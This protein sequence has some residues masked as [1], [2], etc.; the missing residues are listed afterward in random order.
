MLSVASAA[1]RRDP[2]GPGDEP[3]DL[4]K[5][6]LYVSNFNG[7]YGDEWLRK[8]KKRFEAFY[9]ETAFEEGKQGVQIQIENA[10][11]AGSGIAA[12]IKNDRNQVFFTEQVYYNDFVST[13]LLADITDIVTSDLSEYGEAATIA[14]KFYPEQE[15]FYKTDAGRY[16]AIPHYAGFTGII[17]DVDLFDKE[18]LYLSANPNNGNGGF[19]KSK[20]E[21][22]AA[23]PDGVAGSADDG[24]PATY[25]DFFKLFDYIV[26]GAMTPYVWMGK[27]TGYRDWLLQALATDYEGL[28]QMMLSFTFDGNATNLVQSVGA[29]GSVTKKPSTAITNANGYELFTSAGRY[30]A[31]KFLESMVSSTQYFHSRSFGGAHTHTAAQLDF[32][33][34]RPATDKDV[35]ML[36]DGIWWENEA[37]DAFTEIVQK[38]GAQ[39]SKANRKLGF[40]PL[41]KATP[42]K[43][44]EKRT[45]A[46]VLYCVGFINGNCTGVGLDVAKKF[47]KFVNTRESMVEFT[48]ETNTPKALQYTLTEA[49]LASMSYFGKDVMRVKQSA[50]IVYP[51]SRNPLYLENQAAL[52]YVD[53]F[54]SNIGGTNYNNPALTFRTDQ[55]GHKTAE[56]WFAGIAA[57]NTKANWDALYGKYFS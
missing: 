20:D 4:T 21:P 55:T 32:L 1:C 9:A 12:A 5:T 10:K 22:R 47:L 19:I 57:K 8:A 53:T 38:Y 42:D 17:Y 40:L 46:D 48:Q 7:G 39:Y 15:A 56:E 36:V 52:K 13:N 27:G 11:T 31:L 50:D 30:Y 3:V 54:V 45:V 35:A 16:Y 43:I 6:Q 44:G 41:P 23:G 34:S 37:N 14:S 2:N 24:L 51:Y 28:E 33:S 18:D 26:D 49:E 25:A 29:G